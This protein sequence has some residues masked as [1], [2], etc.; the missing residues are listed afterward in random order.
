MPHHVKVVPVRVRRYDA[1][2]DCDKSRIVG[3]R[4]TCS[5]GW[6]GTVR[7]TVRGARADHREHVASVPA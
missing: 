5:C 7:P 1:E 2:L 6:R 3:Y 4:A